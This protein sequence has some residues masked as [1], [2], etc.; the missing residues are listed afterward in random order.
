MTPSTKSPLSQSSQPDIDYIPDYEKYRARTKRRTETEQL[1]EILPPG[2]PPRLSSDLVWDGKD[3]CEVYNWNY[4][5]TD[6]DLDEIEAALA[7]FTG[8]GSTSSPFCPGQVQQR[9][10]L[11]LS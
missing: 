5:L 3:L 6:E 1:K 10:Q 9:I 8:S 11:V 7:H 4:Q 2:F